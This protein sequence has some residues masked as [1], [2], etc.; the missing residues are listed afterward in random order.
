VHKS[1]GLILKK[2]IV[3]LRDREFTAGLIFVAV[4]RVR[5]LEDLLIKP[6]SFERLQRIKDCK[7]LQKRKDEEKRLIS[8]IRN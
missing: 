6:F 1:Q 7:R 3:D 2:A 4:S 8:L 5:T